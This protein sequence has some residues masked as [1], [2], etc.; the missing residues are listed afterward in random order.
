MKCKNKHHTIFN[1]VG[2][3][4]FLP[5]MLLKKVHIDVSLICTVQKACVFKRGNVH[6]QYLSSATFVYP[7]QVVWLCINSCSHSVD[8][9]LEGQAFHNS[10]ISYCAHQHLSV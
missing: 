2:N 3:C 6:V 7:F 4:I 9:S 1:S 5:Y 8:M 10:T